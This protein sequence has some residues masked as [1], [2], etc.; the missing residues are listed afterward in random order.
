MT[1]SGFGTSL[2]Q[3][4]LAPETGGW[5]TSMLQSLLSL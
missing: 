4:A 5:V 1:Q 3:R 2:I